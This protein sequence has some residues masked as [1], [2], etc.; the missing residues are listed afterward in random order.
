MRT[1]CQ[2]K[3]LRY[4]CSYQTIH[5][6]LLRWQREGVFQAILEALVREAESMGLVNWAY[7]SMD[8]S[9]GKS[10]RGGEDCGPSPVDRKKGGIKRS[11][12]VEGNGYPIAIITAPANVPD[13]NLVEATLKV[14]IKPSAANAGVRT[15]LIVDR[16]YR[17]Q[18]VKETIEK[19][20]LVYRAPPR[21]REDPYHRIDIPLTKEERAVR[22]QVE[23]CHSWFVNY[24]ACLVRYSYRKESH[25]AVLTFVA[26]LIWWRRIVSITP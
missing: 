10:R 4:P 2:W 18:K 11:L 25:L 12:L 13:L 14:R 3:A 22:A 5:K 7:M 6:W 21:D 17:G 26:A 23:R 24:R 8:G 19:E 1:G 9:L 20:G 15:T 16:G